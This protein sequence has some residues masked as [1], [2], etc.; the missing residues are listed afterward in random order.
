MSISVD[1]FVMLIRTV[2][3]PETL[4]RPIEDLRVLEVN[5][6]GSVLLE[7]QKKYKADELVIQPSF[8]LDDLV[9]WNHPDN[10]K[11]LRLEHFEKGPFLVIGI[12]KVSWFTR[13]LWGKAHQNI[14]IENSTGE[15]AKVT[16]RMISH[17]PM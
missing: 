1:D 16:S 3:D 4:R 11:I 14:R 15:R 8:F 2:G 7:N 12:E 5:P 10:P 6:D 9:V 13:W 17:C